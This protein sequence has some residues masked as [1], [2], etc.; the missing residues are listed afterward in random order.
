[1][2]KRSAILVM[3][4]GTCAAA[5]T[6]GA[7]RRILNETEVISVPVT[8]L[9]N[10]N[11]FVQGLKQ[12]DFDVLE[13]NVA[14][15][16]TS[17]SIEESGIA[18]ELLIDVSGSMTSRL[19][20]A[21]R[22]ALQFVRLMGPKDSTKITQF[23]EKVTPLSEFS[24]DK[25]LLEAAV[26]KAKIG[27]ATAL[28]NAI[29]TALADLQALKAADEK[30]KDVEP[31]HRA[32]VVLSDGDDTA[33]AIAPDEVMSRAKGVDAMIYSLSL[34]RQNGRPVTDSPSAVFL[35]ELASQ[36]GGTLFFPEVT[37]LQKLYRTL[38]DELRRQ[39]VLGYVSSNATGRV[40]YRAITVRVKNRNN[41]RLR[42]RLGYFPF[43]VRA[44]Q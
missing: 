28:H 13:D 8:V 42:H 37:D 7:Q 3:A 9:D 22:A 30:Q 32:I 16:I 31:R 17:F 21:K 1:M 38:A 11:R 10:R 44:S 29:W 15:D 26:N 43:G 4:I 35:K 34:D 12:A 27:G 24:N 20:E 36:T 40:R 19:G 6:L 25:T 2:M 5:V 23:D 14:Q 18:V 33:S 39:Y 41:L